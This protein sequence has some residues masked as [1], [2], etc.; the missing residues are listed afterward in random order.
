[1][2]HHIGEAPNRSLAPYAVAP[3]RF[4]AQLD[5]L[6]AAGFEAVTLDGLADGPSPARPVVLTFDDGYRSFYDD[7][8]P[9][10]AERD[11]HA[12]VFVVAGAL[13]GVNDW[14]R[15]A[16]AL[17]L[18]DAEQLWGIVD[19]GHEIAVHGWRHRPLVEVESATLERELLAA[20]VVLETLKRAPVRAMSYP[21]GLADERVT[22]IIER[23]GFEAAFLDSR[24]RA[25]GCPPNLGGTRIDVAP[26]TD[27]DALVEQVRAWEHGLAREPAGAVDPLD[28]LVRATARA[29][30]AHPPAAAWGA[31]HAAAAPL[32]GALRAR[33]VSSHER[34]FANLMA[35]D[36]PAAGPLVRALKPLQPA[37]DALLDGQPRSPVW[38]V[39][40]VEEAMAADPQSVMLGPPLLDM[41]RL[42]WGRE[43]TSHGDDMSAYLR[44][45][46]RP[47]GTRAVR[48][49][50]QELP[51]AEVAVL[52]LDAMDPTVDAG[53]A[54]TE[55]AFA[56]V[57][58]G[59]RASGR[60]P[61]RTDWVRLG[62][63]LSA[64]AR[65][66][67]RERHGS[68]W[69]SATWALVQ[70]LLTFAVLAVV[71][72]RIVPL[73]VQR[74]PEFLI[75]GLL[76]WLVF[77]RVVSQAPSTIRG[78]DDLVR[79]A[80]FPRVV[81]PLAPL[82]SAFVDF[83]AQLAVAALILSATGGPSPVRLLALA[84]AILALAAVAAA[85]S[86]LVAGLVAL[87][88][89]VGN[90]VPVLLGL[91]FYALPIVYPTTRV[92]AGWR[93]A[94]WADPLVGIIETFRCA[95]YGGPWPPWAA[96]A[97]SAVASCASLALAWT[98]FA[99]ASD[100]IA[101]AA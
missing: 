25:D 100:S 31:V 7:A 16:A 55:A 3:E 38:G 46:G 53:W 30:V 14:D 50:L 27:P 48:A 18:M 85:A 70:P 72:G 43:L 67:I 95:L 44:H 63:A 51:V 66:D 35:T 74:Y 6:A 8:A 96:L 26:D 58:S 13:G 59:E 37:L 34:T 64:L 41:V 101:A 42:L 80:A 65:Q 23:C 78:R 2:W 40:T 29:G 32:V 81:L 5:A 79:V 93:D 94:Y 19:D 86:I 49:A 9:L 77:L 99:R 84:P 22:A 98:W 12:V 1:M 83:A 39:P 69:L 88:R 17:A 90:L 28:E 73:G 68:T 45:A 21:N 56:G 76:P 47:H 62:T 91:L 89:D 11:M 20:R 57:R 61:A 82:V 10:L 92:P 33:G 15:H 75:V 97:W 24:W 87:Y 60:P 54:P 52:A 71:F 4:A 36:D